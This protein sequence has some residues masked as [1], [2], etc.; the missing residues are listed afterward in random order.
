[1]QSL[2]WRHMDVVLFLDICKQH[3]RYLMKFDSMLPEI[4]SQWEQS[5]SI[6]SDNVLDEPMITK[7][8]DAYMRPQA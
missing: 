8:A 1:M 4:C 7:F 3:W 2:R 5:R 6:T